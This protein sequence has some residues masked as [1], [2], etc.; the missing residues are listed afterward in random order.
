[1]SALGSL[2]A[3]VVRRRKKQAAAVCGRLGVPSGDVMAWRVATAAS[4]GGGANL[5]AC[6]DGGVVW[7]VHLTA[8]DCNEEAG[9]AGPSLPSLPASR[10]FISQ[11]RW[12]E[13]APNSTLAGPSRPR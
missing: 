5:L 1:M 9:R 8:P 4:D 3:G 2:S 11:L 7:C 12:M 13:Q 10:N 6:D